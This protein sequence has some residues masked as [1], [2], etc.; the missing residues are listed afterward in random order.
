MFNSFSW[1]QYLIFIAA[2]LTL[3]YLSIL[4]LYYRKDLALI[5]T[6]KK[7]TIT[8]S[9]TEP[10]YYNP[11]SPYLS[12]YRY[13]TKKRMAPRVAINPKQKNIF[14]PMI[15]RTAN[16]ISSTTKPAARYPIYW[17]FNPLNSIGLLIPLLIL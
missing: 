13:T 14:T 2:I 10:K 3:Y 17:A 5:F 15:Y 8:Q 7:G 12:L 6:S 1:E 16:K 4:L 9:K 11:Y